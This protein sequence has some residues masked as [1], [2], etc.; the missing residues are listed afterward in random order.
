V[1]LSPQ[2]RE[3]TEDKLLREIICGQE[4][5]LELNLELIHH[6]RFV[7]G[8][9]SSDVS[10]PSIRATVPYN[11]SLAQVQELGARAILEDPLSKVM[12][13]NFKVELKFFKEATSAWVA[14]ADE[15][16][17]IRA[18][19]TALDHDNNQLRL[20]CRAIQDSSARRASSRTAHSSPFAEGIEV[21]DAFLAGISCA[22]LGLSDSIASDGTIPAPTPPHVGIN[23]DDVSLNSAYSMNSRTMQH[24]QKSYNDSWSSPGDRVRVGAPSSSS[25]PRAGA[26]RAGGPNADKLGAWADNLQRRI[27]RASSKP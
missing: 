23:D 3:G 17:W 25:Q 15:I 24:F 7:G 2:E 19:S 26:G 1:K 18:K 14:V 10:V 11:T 5:A 27:S 6:E 22:E 4:R 16:H 20:L 9:G 21:F 12:R 13:G 8:H